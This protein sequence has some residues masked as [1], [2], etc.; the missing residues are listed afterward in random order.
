MWQH[1]F[2]TIKLVLLVHGECLEQ[3]KQTFENINIYV[4]LQM[5]LNSFAQPTLLT[6]QNTNLNFKEFKVNIQLTTFY[7]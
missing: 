7:I 5:L 1:T 4:F 2:L 6:K 3:D